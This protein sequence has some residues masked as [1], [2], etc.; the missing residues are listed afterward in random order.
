MDT[1]LIELLVCPICKSPLQRGEHGP[2]LVCLAD[3]LSFPIRDGIPIMLESEAVPMD[4][5]ETTPAPLMP[6]SPAAPTVP[7]PGADTSV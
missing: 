1:R 4:A 6:A 5:P 2:S 7:G 3:R